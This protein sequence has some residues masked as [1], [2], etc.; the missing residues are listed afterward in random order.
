[1]RAWVLIRPLVLV[2]AGVAAGCGDP[3]DGAAGEPSGPTMVAAPSGVDPDGGRAPAGA[4]DAGGLLPGP[5]RGVAFYSPSHVT[6]TAGWT[7]A[8]LAEHLRALTSWWVGR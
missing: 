7:R 3:D 4:D 1:M 2:A 5:R 6:D 8:D